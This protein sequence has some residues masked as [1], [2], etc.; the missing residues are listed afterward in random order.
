MNWVCFL[1]SY[2]FIIINKT[3]STRAL[4]KLGALDTTVITRES[5]FGQ[6]INR[7]GKITDL[8]HK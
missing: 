7:V 3:I 6:V 5:K 8:G 2:F 4:Y 1:R